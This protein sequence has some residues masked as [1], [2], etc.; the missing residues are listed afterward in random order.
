MMTKSVLR[1]HSSTRKKNRTTN[2][3]GNVREC[4]LNFENGTQ[5]IISKKENRG[6]MTV[7]VLNQ[8]IENSFVESVLNNYKHSKTLE[9]FAARCGFNS[10]K[11]FTRHF[12]KNFNI[13]PKQWILSIKKE[14]MIAQLQNSDNTIKQIADDLGF[15]NVS[16][17]SD[18]CLKKTGMRP[19][20]IRKGKKSQQ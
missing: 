16:H 17:L 10:I 19:E 11:T 8:V 14:E 7:N 1:N 4:I 20:D 2:I 6:L 12:K 5:K 15:S 9:D 18:F 3:Y 13:T